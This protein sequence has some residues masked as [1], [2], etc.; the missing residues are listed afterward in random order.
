MGSEM[1]I[2][3]SLGASRRGVPL[4]ARLLK[5]Q[6]LASPRLD[7]SP[8]NSSVAVDLSSSAAAVVGRPGEKLTPGNVQGN[9]VAGV[10]RR[11]GCWG[12]VCFYTVFIV[13]V[14]SFIFDL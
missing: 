2:R 5:V 11:G 3:D 12:C 1:C 4:T 13:L 9:V 6:D 14:F 8:P 10:A 7:P